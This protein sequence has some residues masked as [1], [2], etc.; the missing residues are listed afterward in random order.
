M[1]IFRA[2]RGAPDD[3]TQARVAASAPPLP[4]SAPPP[5]Y[6][7]IDPGEHAVPGRARPGATCVEIFANPAFL[8]DEAD[9]LDASG[10]RRAAADR[11]SS[12]PDL[13]PP[14]VR[15]AWE[16]TQSLQG[17]YAA[18]FAHAVES[19]GPRVT[20]LDG[21]GHEGHD[22]NALR[23]A[24][25]TN[26]RTLR[27]SAHTG[28]V[29]RRLRD[30]CSLAV[31]A[32]LT[33][34]V[35][36]QMITN[37]P[38]THDIDF[39][40]FNH[41][42]LPFGSLGASYGLM[43]AELVKAPLTAGLSY[44]TM[45]RH[46]M[47]DEYLRRTERTLKLVNEVL[48]QLGAV[49]AAGL[50]AMAAT[51]RGA[52]MACLGITEMARHLSTVFTLLNYLIAPVRVGLFAHNELSRAGHL[53]KPD[54]MDP[55]TGLLRFSSSMSDTIRALL[56][57]IGTQSRHALMSLRMETLLDNA[58]Y[59]SLRIRALQNMTESPEDIET[60]FQRL[61]M[62][63]SCSTNEVLELL[64]S[65]PTA[66]GEALSN[67]Q[68]P[69]SVRNLRE[70]AQH[71]KP[72]G[73]GMTSSAL[74]GRASLGLDVKPTQNHWGKVLGPHANWWDHIQFP[75]RLGYRVTLMLQYWLASVVRNLSAPCE[76]PLQ[77]LI[78]R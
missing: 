41:A 33:A 20:R 50:P 60:V 5:P 57:Q 47:V 35:V 73:V 64:A 14:V 10:A 49:G 65:N 43:C 21:I 74:D 78:Q 3:L 31:S 75:M 67:A 36:T 4:E 71:L 32:T 29:V 44:Q 72:F 77:R 69:A 6:S 18:E 7:E 26:F 23:E 17:F 24:L 2:R 22:R 8:A 27:V 76:G 66:L 28:T 59:L 15:S 63:C 68:C 61:G 45:A 56:S 11:V 19:A 34:G 52:A 40:S 37:T 12:Q 25:E 39:D 58:D 48:N 16:A 42:D 53:E 38:A 30:V 62:L 54:W 46:H 51:Q 55:L 9:H 70:L 1:S 13:L